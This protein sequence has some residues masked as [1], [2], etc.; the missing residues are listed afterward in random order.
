MARYLE[1]H[2]DHPS[3]LFL[4]GLVEAICEDS[5]KELVVASVRNWAVNSKERYGVSPNTFS[6]LYTLLKKWIADDEDGLMGSLVASV[7][8]G[9]DDPTFV[10]SVFTGA[11]VPV[12]G[13]LALECLVAKHSSML[14][15]AQSRLSELLSND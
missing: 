15:D 9:F 1:S 8:E 7:L 14:T 5:D 2:P 6:R 3:L 13:E 11:T 12:E 10:R 4:R